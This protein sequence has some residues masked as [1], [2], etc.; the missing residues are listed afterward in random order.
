[1]SQNIRFSQWFSL[2]MTPSLYTYRNYLLLLGNFIC[3]LH[4]YHCDC[5]SKGDDDDDDDDDDDQDDVDD[6]HYV[7]DDDGDDDHYVD[8]DDGDQDDNDDY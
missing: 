2:T 3:L 6:D 1:M 7:D 5:E 8:D 4:R